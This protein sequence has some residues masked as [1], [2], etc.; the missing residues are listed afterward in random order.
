MVDYNTLKAFKLVVDLNSFSAAAK[1]LNVSQPAITNRIKSLER[2][3]GAP[4][5]VRKGKRF[6][7]SPYGEILYKEVDSA[8]ESFDRIR[9]V[10]IK[11]S[12]SSREK[13]RFA[14]ST[15]V[16]NYFIPE[17]I[18][19]FLAKEKVKVEMFIGNT[20]EVVHNLLSRYYTVG[21]VEGKVEE[22]EL[23]VIPIKED[24]IILVKSAG[25]NLP[26]EINLEDITNYPLVIREEGSG[27]RKLI[28]EVLSNFG[29]T[30]NC[31]NILAEIGNTTGIINFVSKNKEVYAFVPEVAVKE[32][33]SVKPVK[34]KDIS[35]KREFSLITHK[36]A[37]FNI[38]TKNFI[39]Y[40]LTFQDKT[41]F[42]DSIAKPPKLS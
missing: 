11:L 15:T 2:F 7:L 31:L 42:S 1:V 36:E 14:T 17:I 10:I 40:L 30:P 9:N 26:E 20:E 5:F 19:P 41:A 18:Q 3:L 23:N 37:C 33:T 39:S 32:N 4:L 21:I 34:I 35:I 24:R 29:I 12:K 25:S 8:I 16:G 13:L 22:A 38:V 28:E 27:T 6:V